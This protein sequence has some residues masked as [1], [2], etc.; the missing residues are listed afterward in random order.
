MHGSA[1]EPEALAALKT[2]TGNYK[3][4]LRIIRFTQYDEAG[5]PIKKSDGTVKNLKALWQ[6]DYDIKSFENI[7]EVAS[8][9]RKAGIMVW[10]GV[11]DLKQYNGGQA[12]STSM[13]NTQQEYL[14]DTDDEDVVSFR[15]TPNI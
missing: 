14:L 9:L 12:V 15:F 6:S 1:T 4:S 13:G 8:D 5:Q 11:E 2:I 10:A 3:S 7:S